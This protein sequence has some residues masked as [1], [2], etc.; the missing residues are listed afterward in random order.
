MDE[1]VCEVVNV[2]TIQL[3]PSLYSII[4]YLFLLSVTKV[5]KP[6]KIEPGV[7]II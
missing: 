1:R 7:N 2:V 3:F 5:N 4:A 6:Y